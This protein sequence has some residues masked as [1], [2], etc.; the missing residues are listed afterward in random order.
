VNCFLH[1][2]REAIIPSQLTSI[3][4]TIWA[5]VSPF[6]NLFYTFKKV[7]V[8]FI[9]TL[10]AIFIMLCLGSLSF[11]LGFG[12]LGIA[13]ST[14]ASYLMQAVANVLLIGKYSGYEKHALF[15][16]FLTFYKKLFYSLLALLVLYVGIYFYDGILLN[17]IIVSAYSLFLI[18]KY[19]HFADQ[20]RHYLNTI[21]S[22]I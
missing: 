15:K 18:F 3:G 21:K 8:F 19:R 1:N 10:L 13:T 14:S 16:L 22:R 12:L 17:L 7:R 11:Y 5:I 4:I 9:T 2:F 20:L 6:Y